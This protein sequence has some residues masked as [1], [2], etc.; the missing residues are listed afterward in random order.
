M[1]ITR[2]GVTANAFYGPFFGQVDDLLCDRSEVEL[3]LTEHLQADL[4]G[5][6]PGPC[7]GK[8]LSHVKKCIASAVDP[9]TLHMTSHFGVGTPKEAW[10]LGSLVLYEGSAPH[11]ATSHARLHAHDNHDNPLMPLTLYVV[12]S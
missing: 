10:K 8:C 12:A 6:I 7:A 5:F 3:S 9:R 2:A 11:G 1:N 4:L